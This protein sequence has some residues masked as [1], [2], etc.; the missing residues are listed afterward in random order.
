MEEKVHRVELGS[1]IEREVA[2]RLSVDDGRMCTSWMDK[3]DAW[4]ENGV[5]FLEK[6]RWASQW[7]IPW[8][9]VHISIARSEPIPTKD[10][11]S[12]LLGSLT[13]ISRI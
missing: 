7:L 12:G 1:L 9:A 5:K 8:V 13:R 3:T 11:L 4:L 2:E 10:P 6:S